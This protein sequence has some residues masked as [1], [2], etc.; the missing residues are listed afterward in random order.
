MKLPLAVFLL[1][2]AVTGAMAQTQPQ[3]GNPPGPPV[4]IPFQAL[5]NVIRNSDAD[6]PRRY[7]PPPAVP[8]GTPNNPQANPPAAPQNTVSPGR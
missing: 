3:N 7:P 1:G 2:L 5:G 8:P 4:A 6:P